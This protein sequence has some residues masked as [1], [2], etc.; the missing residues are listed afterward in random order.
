MP[1][2]SSTVE[3]PRRLTRTQKRL[4][5]KSPDCLEADTRSTAH[6]EVCRAPVSYA[7]WLCIRL[8][9]L[10]A[11]ELPLVVVEITCPC[12]TQGKKRRKKE[13]PL[14]LSL[15][16][17]WYSP[18]GKTKVNRLL[19][20]PVT[21]VEALEVWFPLYLAIPCIPTAVTALLTS[22]SQ[23]L[24][25]KSV[26]PSLQHSTRRLSSGLLQTPHSINTALYGLLSNF[27]RSITGVLELHRASLRTWC[28]GHSRSQSGRTT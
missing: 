17:R 20:R 6:E 23:R 21:S 4:A 22:H 8:C 10:C 2:S 19:L 3:L 5:D 13:K 18:S 24:S 12:H 9:C 27:G 28:H 16:V 11:G 14:Q 7:T 1:S 26:T 15:Y 25:S